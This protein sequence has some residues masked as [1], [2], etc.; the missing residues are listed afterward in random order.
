MLPPE[1]WYLIASILDPIDFCSFV[2]TCQ[3]FYSF[4]NILL[5]R[6]T[7][8]RKEILKRDLVECNIEGYH[9]N[10]EAFIEKYTTLNGVK[11]GSYSYKCGAWNGTH[12][13][14]RYY[15]KGKIHGTQVQSFHNN[16]FVTNYE[17]GLRHGK[18]Y[19][20][21]KYNGRRSTSFI[22]GQHLNDLRYG[23]WRF[24]IIPDLREDERIREL[25]RLEIWDGRT[26]VYEQEVPEQRC[27]WKMYFDVFAW[28]LK[29]ASQSDSVVW[30]CYHE[31]TQ[32]KDYL[33][34]KGISFI[35]KENANENH[36]A[37]ITSA[38]KELE[39]I[40]DPKPRAIIA[41]DE[42]PAKLLGYKKIKSYGRVNASG[43]L[44]SKISWYVRDKTWVSKKFLQDPYFEVLFA[45]EENPG[46]LCYM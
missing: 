13:I 1:I 35:S 20:Y 10:H 29:N 26:L 21:V 27:Y 23:E 9:K 39:A 18:Y 41:F 17:H 15:I 28:Y 42:N 22:T 36:V 12:K 4:Y 25:E 3:L 5:P 19:A 46:M 44:G 31:N 33:I 43:H 32:L 38:Y 37:F 8:K 6:I 2:E 11:H 14:K 30:I 45:A 34:D 40:S 24:Y 16:Y 7:A